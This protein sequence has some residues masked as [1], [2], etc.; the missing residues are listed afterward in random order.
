MSIV[1]DAS[2]LR[3]ENDQLAPGNSMAYKTDPSGTKGRF[4]DTG[5]EST[6]AVNNVATYVFNHNLNKRAHVVAEL[7]T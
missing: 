1:S 5:V 4:P 3:L 2:G 7:A 6:V